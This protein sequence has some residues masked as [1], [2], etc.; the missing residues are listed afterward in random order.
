MVLVAR[1]LCQRLYDSSEAGNYLKLYAL[2]V[3]MLYCDALTDA[4]TKG[5][6]QQT[7]CVRYNILTAAMDV[8]FLY[9]LLPRYGMEGYY[10]S[11]LITH[12]LNFALSLRRL[13][14]IT[15]EQLPWR[16]PALS[17]LAGVFS[18]WACTFVP[19][20]PLQV[21]CFSLILGSLLFLLQI[22]GREDLR[23]ISGLIRKKDLTA[24]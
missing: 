1:P 16:I 18:V 19:E 11:F 23:W 6:G 24:R 9:L 3:P 5:L 14:K 21:I 20:A 7:A 4:M 13:L 17:A 2:L 12:L 10:F 22:I 15:E 8:V